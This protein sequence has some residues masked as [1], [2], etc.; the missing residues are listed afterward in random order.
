MWYSYL[1]LD[2]WRW[3]EC[4]QW[5]RWWYSW[6][7]CLLIYLMNEAEVCPSFS[8]SL[9]LA[10]SC[11]IFTDWIQL[12]SLLTVYDWL[13]YVRKWLSPVHR[14]APTTYN[15]WISV[16]V[17]LV[18]V[19]VYNVSSLYWSL[20]LGRTQSVIS[21]QTWTRPHCTVH[22]PRTGAVCQLVSTPAQALHHYTGN[23]RVPTCLIDSHMCQDVSTVSFLSLQSLTVWTYPIL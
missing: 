9:W 21:S 12:I 4:S 23:N 13:L 22:W 2:C 3:Q 18:T 17:C 15:L 14:P 1:Y 10:I 20:G 6:T 5:E 11:N 7:W 19:S 8:H 16:S